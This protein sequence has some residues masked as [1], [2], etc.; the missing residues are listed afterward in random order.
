[1]DAFAR[2]VALLY[3]VS[4][5]PMLAAWFLIHPLAGFWRRMGARRTYLAVGCVMAATAA[6][7][8]ALR[9]PALAV[10]F[11]F[12]P[13]L[14]AL[15]APFVGVGIWLG[16]LRGRQLGLSVLVGL[17]EVSD[18]YPSRLITEGIY[19][20]LR[21]PRYAEGVF[22]LVAGA[23]VSN[24]LAVYTMLVLYLPL[25]ALIVRLEERELRSRFGAAFDDYCR[26]V[27]RFVPRF[28]LE[29]QDRCLSAR[30]ASL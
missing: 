21:N 13:L 12:Q 24:H 2:L 9:E 8:Y 6:V 4:V 23:L 26:R 30:S 29:R 5:P 15:A 28:F 27:P 18:T 14:A 20:R 25:I 11:G 22:L 10:A 19:S 1:M 7:C 3:L 16:V 17:P